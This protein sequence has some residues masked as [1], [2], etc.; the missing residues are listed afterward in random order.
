MRL[1]RFLRGL[2]PVVAERAP[3][4]FLR[5]PRRTFGGLGFAGAC[6]VVSSAA[7]SSFALTGPRL[8]RPRLRWCL[9]RRVFGLRGGPS[10]V[11]SEMRVQV[12][13][14]VSHKPAQ[15]TPNRSSAGNPPPLHC[16]NAD[17]LF[18]AAQVA[19]R[20]GFFVNDFV[21]RVGF[22]CVPR[23]IRG[24]QRKFSA[25]TGV[26]SNASLPEVLHPPCIVS[27][28]DEAFVGVP[29]SPNGILAQPRPPR[30]FG[31]G[32]ILY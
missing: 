29:R 14:P 23:A 25:T 9:P 1:L 15:A 21:H 31:D 4:F 12:A 22:L 26:P 8:R 2:G 17:W 5:S 13:L 7:S 6:R 18:I 24:F 19:P 3:G 30:H 28:F 10:G 27:G 20:A 32:V 11:R 16:A